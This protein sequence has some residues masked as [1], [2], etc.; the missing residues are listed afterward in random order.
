MLTTKK[1][2]EWTQWGKEA[3][4]SAR[5]CALRN[6]KHPDYD[7]PEKVK[8]FYDR[9]G[10]SYMLSDDR[11]QKLK[12]K[13][14]YTQNE[15]SEAHQLFREEFNRSRAWYEQNDKKY[16]AILDKYR[17]TFEVA[18]KVAKAVDVSDIEDGFPCGWAHLV[19][20]EY[21]ETED[22]RKALGHF[23]DAKSEVYKYK[24]PI[25]FPAYGQCIAFDERIA[26]KVNEF[27][28]DQGI[29]ASVHPIID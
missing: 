10:D 18:E 27:L 7:T 16:Q 13:F 29:F 6:N 14:G 8:E 20:Q 3:F 21:P 15:V 28:R 17:P 2:K 1:R 23:S 12:E 26:Q 22:L 5:N 25:E 4:H 11:T 24:L 19:L 9:Y